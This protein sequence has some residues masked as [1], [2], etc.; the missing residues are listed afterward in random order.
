MNTSDDRRILFVPPLVTGGV[1][2]SLRQHPNRNPQDFIFGIPEDGAP[3]PTWNSWTNVVFPLVLG[4]LDL[5]TDVAAVISYYRAGHHWWFALGLMFIVG[6][7]L[8][9]AIVVL[10]GEAK[11]RRVFVALHLG[12]LAEAWVSLMDASYSHVLVSLRVVEP[13]YESTPQLMLQM[14]VLLLEWGRE[15]AKWPI[16]RIFSIVTSWFSLA[17]AVT[18]LVAEHPLSNVSTT[19]DASS[20]PA[21]CPGL[22]RLLFG[23]VPPNGTVEVYRSRWHSQNF[24]WAFLVYQGLEVGARVISLALLALVWREKFFF[25][26]LYLWISRTVIL[27]LS[28]GKGDE[29]LRFRSQLRFVGMPFMDSVMDAL[30]SYDAACALTTAEFAVCV[31]V[32]STTYEGAEHQVPRDPRLVWTSLAVVFMA[33]KLVLGCL[34]VRPFKRNIRFGLGDEEGDQTAGNH[35]RNMASIGAGDLESGRSSRG[36]DVTALG[37]KRVGSIS[38]RGSGAVVELAGPQRRSR[39]FV[40]EKKTEPAEEDDVEHW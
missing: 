4:Y 9:A 28:L 34:I 24:V 1:P 10:S 22:T 20:A 18:G 8:F 14:Y 32:G 29:L 27:R 23:T 11:L 3:V 17:Y 13:L 31:G 33:G 5:G 12:L 40:Q 26:L 35:R 6:P 21:R 38:R 15:G 19:A 16:W 37:G 2:R 39:R 30:S 36:P 7:A 25:A